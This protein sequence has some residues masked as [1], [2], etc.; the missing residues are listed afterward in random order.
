MSEVQ[1]RFL[2]VIAGLR[3][4]LHRYCARMTGS[5]IEGEDLVQ[6]TLVR[7]HV[8]LAQLRDLP[9]LRG[10]LFR[11][12]H[13]IAIDHLR[14]RRYAGVVA[15]REAEGEEDAA[16]D[17]DDD[18]E[19]R[20]AAGQA[21]QLALSRFAPLPPAQRAA[22]I[23]KDVLDE[24]LEEIAAMLEMTV[25]AVKA[26]L[27]RGRARL[28]G[29]IVTAGEG[30]PG[31]PNPVLV[32]YAERFNARDW[33]AVR[34]ML[35]EDVQ[36]DLVSREKRRGIG[37]VSGYFANYARRPAVHL[38]VGWWDGRELLLVREAATEER[39]GYVVE[40]GVDG[41]RVSVIRDFR[42]VPYLFAP[43]LR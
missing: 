25:P 14:R 18:A 37:P 42:Y 36:L 22:V 10:W 28:A 27:H 23:L 43:H 31:E 30:R 32:R 33:D 19:T 2:E 6:D 29:T 26:A 17:P 24:S 16:I 5:F 34:A 40:L 13:R 8:E 21:T 41:D 3:P 4:D 12:A 38:S 1:P 35:V 20:L 39:P 7:A 11:I 15:A 9:A